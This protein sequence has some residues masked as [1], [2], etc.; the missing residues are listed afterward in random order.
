[1]KKFPDDVSF[2]SQKVEEMKDIPSQ[3]AQVVMETKE[4]FAAEE[5]ESSSSQQERISLN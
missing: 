1:M 3:V 2:I 4:V 5:E